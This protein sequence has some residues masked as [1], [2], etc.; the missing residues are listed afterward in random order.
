MD[1]IRA[2]FVIPGKSLGTP[3]IHLISDTVRGAA[4]REGVFLF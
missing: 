3:E 2:D 4:E 1:Q